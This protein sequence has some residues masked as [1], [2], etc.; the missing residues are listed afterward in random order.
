[1]LESR[2]DQREPSIG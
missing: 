2:E 1:M